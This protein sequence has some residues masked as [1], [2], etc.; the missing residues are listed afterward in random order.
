MVII[1]YYVLSLIFF[2]WN[3]INIAE[4]LIF[5]SGELLY[6]IGISFLII[7]YSKKIRY[8][9]FKCYFTYVLLFTFN[10]LFLFCFLWYAALPLLI[11]VTFSTHRSMNKELNKIRKEELEG[12]WCC[13]SK[14]RKQQIEDFKF[15]TIEE[16]QKHRE[17]CA[18]H[19]KKLKPLL[20]FMISV[21]LPIAITLCL[22]LSGIGYR[23]YGYPLVQILY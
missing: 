8:L 23:W 15:K 1:L 6:I 9:T 11:L 4:K 21:F 19:P 14:Y 13:N 3:N 20:L 16:Q 7:S 17:Y 5:T 22:W 18:S 2:P 12:G 10:I